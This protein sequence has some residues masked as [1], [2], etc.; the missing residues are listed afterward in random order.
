MT[1]TPEDARQH[2]REAASAADGLLRVLAR[3]GAYLDDD[4][5][6]A[7][8]GAVQAW[9]E[10]EPYTAVIRETMEHWRD[11]RAQSLIVWEL[12]QRAM[13]SLD[14]EGK[15]FAAQPYISLHLIDAAVDHGFAVGAA[16]TDEE[17][18]E[19]EG[20]AW[21]EIR[22]VVPVRELPQWAPSPAPVP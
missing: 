6:E 10:R 2:V 4:V 19:A 11:P 16:L 17:T 3:S 21:V 14:R 22:L 1:M 8:T 20:L 7:L 18:A 15:A 9:Q 12:R 13:R 5:A